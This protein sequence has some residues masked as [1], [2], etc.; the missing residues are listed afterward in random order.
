MFRF[1]I[2]DVLWLT[3]VVGIAL[4]WLSSH[5]SAQKSIRNLKVQVRHF[6]AKL[7][8]ETDENVHVSGESGEYIVTPICARASAGLPPFPWAV[9]SPPP[10]S[11]N[12]NSN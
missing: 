2:R 5:G 8:I 12:T 10:T 6:A 7:A 11:A 1:S 4:A 3:V 9:P